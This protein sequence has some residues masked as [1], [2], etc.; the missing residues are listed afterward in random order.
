MQSMQAV[1]MDDMQST[2]NESGIDLS[3]D[4]VVEIDTTQL[5]DRCPDFAV[6]SADGKSL[7]LY[8]IQSKPA[9]TANSKTR[10]I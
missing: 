10:K 1:N 3:Y 7:N 4:M 6:L 9:S 8:E 5:G 2:G